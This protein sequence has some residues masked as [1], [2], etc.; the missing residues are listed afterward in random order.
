MKGFFLNGE[1]I[2]EK[3]LKSILLNQ[4]INNKLI[5][6]DSLN[7]SSLVELISDYIDEDN[8]DLYSQ[9][10]LLNKDYLLAILYLLKFGNKDKNNKIIENIIKKSDSKNKTETIISE[11]RNDEK[12]DSDID[13]SDLNDFLEKRALTQTKFYNDIDYNLKNLKVNSFSYLYNENINVKTEADL[14]KDRG[15]YKYCYIYNTPKLDL[16]NGDFLYI[17]N[18]KTLDKSLGSKKA[19]LGRFLDR[20]GSDK[21]KKQFYQFYENVKSFYPVRDDLIKDAYAIFNDFEFFIKNFYSYLCMYFGYEG[22]NFLNK[23]LSI[24]NE[25][26]NYPIINIDLIELKKQFMYYYFSDKSNDDKTE[27]LK[28][29]FAF[30]FNENIEKLTTRIQEKIIFDSD[31]W[32]NKFSITNIKIFNS[33][34]KILYEY[35]KDSIPKY[36]PTD[37]AFLFLTG[38]MYNLEIVKEI[39]SK[40]GT[41]SGTIIKD[42]ELRDLEN[43]NSNTYKTYKIKFTFDNN[44][45]N[46]FKFS[47]NEITS[48]NDSQLEE[49]KIKEINNDLDSFKKANLVEKNFFKYDTETINGN[50]ILKLKEIPTTVI[51]C[52]KELEKRTK[53]YFLGNTKIQTIEIFFYTLKEKEAESEINNFVNNNLIENLPDELYSKVAIQ[54]FKNYLNKKYHFRGKIDEKLNFL[55]DNYLNQ[56]LFIKDNNIITGIKNIYKEIDD[57]DDKLE[58]ASKLFDEFFSK[59]NKLDG[60]IYKRKKRYEKYMEAV[61]S[62]LNKTN[63]VWKNY[64]KDT[65]YVRYYYKTKGT[66]TKETTTAAKYLPIMEKIMHYDWFYDELIMNSKKDF[67]SIPVPSRMN[68]KF[69]AVAYVN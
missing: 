35:P 16:N 15:I 43:L 46:D 33:D 60:N 11:L 59:R 49:D 25:F 4:D 22:T 12:E 13:F 64:R 66:E 54:I 26:L 38:I 1:Y 2:D 17:K 36:V 69:T 63:Y 31:Y 20:G 29:L 51:E 47:K 32:E 50:T 62:I 28:K 37:K 53:A 8:L 40:I 9:L 21:E 30:K 65:E 18:N 5:S 10:L 39:A 27:F 67:K 3:Y 19:L 52:I 57:F 34:K 23:D 45:N 7:Y 6:D 41:T 55:D 24:L 44:F 14:S 68:A 61:K 56:C 48:L 58:K 42:I